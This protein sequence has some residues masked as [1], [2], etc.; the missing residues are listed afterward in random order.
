VS[1]PAGTH[2][3][4]AR[5]SFEKPRGCGY[6]KEGGLYMVSGALAG[7]C[8]RMPW[9][10]RACEYCGSGIKPCRGWTWTSP[11]SLLANGPVPKCAEPYCF[12]PLSDVAVEKGKE[13]RVGLIWIGEKFYPTVE[14]FSREAAAR[15]VS[16]RIPHV[17]KG[18][19]AGETWILLAHRRGLFE[20]KECGD[21]LCE[22]YNGDD[23]NGAECRTAC[24]TPAI[25]HAFKPERVE[26]VV[27]ETATAEEVAALAERGISA[28]IVRQLD[29]SGTPRLPGAE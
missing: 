29:A 1:A 10:L 27:P 19:K 4:G 28:V 7:I 11:F 26:Q 21:T 16:R 24:W 18:F 17:P 12:C 20:A 22:H 15:G 14:A 25:V 3:S 8:G 5:V 13:N 2:P 6:R 23:Q 9:P